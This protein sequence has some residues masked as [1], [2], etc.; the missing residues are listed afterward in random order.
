M[1][2]AEWKELLF[3]KNSKYFCENGIVATIFAKN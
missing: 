2:A 3:S 1:G